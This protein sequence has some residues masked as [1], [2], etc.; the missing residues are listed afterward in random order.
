MST[1]LNFDGSNLGTFD[2]ADAISSWWLPAHNIRQRGP[3][4]IHTFFRLDDQPRRMPILLMRSTTPTIEPVLIDELKPLFG[5]CKNGFHRLSLKHHMRKTKLSLPW[6]IGHTQNIC[7]N[8]RQ[9]QFLATPDTPFIPLSTA[10]IRPFA[11]TDATNGHRRLHQDIQKTFVFLDLVGSSCRIENIMLRPHPLASEKFIDM[12]QASIDYGAT[13]DPF[14][15]T[16]KIDFTSLIGKNNSGND[17]VIP[18]TLGEKLGKRESRPNNMMS[19]LHAY[20]DQRIDTRPRALIQMLGIHDD[21]SEKI[22]QLSHGIQRIITRLSPKNYN[23]KDR[24]VEAAESII[25]DHEN[26]I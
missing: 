15:Q 21:A 20:C 13:T 6:I 5:L 12:F 18:M 14:D 2:Y 23:S 16:L 19:G 22:E 1:P 3:G 25:I 10:T 8:S 4:V 26:T 17:R 9:G 7:Y 11:E 24:I